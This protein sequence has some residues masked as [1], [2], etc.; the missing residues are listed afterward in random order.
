MLFD[1]RG[2]PQAL[3]MQV[4]VHG[5]YRKEVLH[6][7]LCQ[8]DAILHLKPRPSLSHIDEPQCSM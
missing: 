8:N 3:S 5:L 1:E 6:H 7:N 2:S 4:L